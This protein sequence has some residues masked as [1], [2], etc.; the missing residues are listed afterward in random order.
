MKILIMAILVIIS[1]VVCVCMGIFGIACITNA[2]HHQKI[3]G[4][5]IGGTIILIAIAFH[6]LSTHWLHM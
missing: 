4:Y 2:S 5:A 1:L 3:K 6:L